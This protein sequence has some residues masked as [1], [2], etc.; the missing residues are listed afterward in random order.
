[1]TGFVFD[2]LPEAEAALARVNTYA[3]YPRENT[4]LLQGGVPAT[5]DS[6]CNLLPHPDG[7]QWAI[8][9]DY[10]TEAALS[11]LSAVEIDWWSN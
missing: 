6:W 9:A 2:T 10:V 8:L 1:M 11:D 4:D 7:T 5:T 3:G